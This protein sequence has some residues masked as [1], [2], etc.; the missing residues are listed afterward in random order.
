MA[1]NLHAAVVARPWN[2][3]EKTSV[4][5]TGAA[6]GYIGQELARKLLA[7]QA[8]QYMRHALAT[9]L[10]WLGQCWLFPTTRRALWPISFAV[11]AGKS[12]Q[13]NLAFVVGGGS[14]FVT[15]REPRRH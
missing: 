11:R 8:T 3:S 15:F 1:L 10:G 14:R 6:I 12:R 13:C 4:T 2:R 7:L 5:L 9:H